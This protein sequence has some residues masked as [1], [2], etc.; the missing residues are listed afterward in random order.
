L[1]EE[2]NAQLPAHEKE[3]DTKEN[4]ENSSLI[5]KNE[6]N[7]HDEEMNN[8]LLAMGAILTCLQINGMTD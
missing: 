4:T 8:I 2:L 1:T 3:L 7:P 6:T 5:S